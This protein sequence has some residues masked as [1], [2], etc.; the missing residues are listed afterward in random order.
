MGSAVERRRREAVIPGGAAGAYGRPNE[1]PANLTVPSVRRRPLL[2][3][4]PRGG[5]KSPAVAVATS[6]KKNVQMPRP[7]EFRREQGPM[8]TFS[9]LETNITPASQHAE[10][11][12]DASYDL[13]GMVHV[14]EKKLECFLIPA[15][16]A[17][18]RRRRYSAR[19]RGSV[20]LIAVFV[21]ALLSSLVIGMLQMNTEEI[22]LMQNHVYAV[23]ALAVAEAGLNDAFA[24]IRA[25]DDWDAG[26]AD[27]SFGAHVY[28]VKVSGTLPA[29][30]L[31]ST[32]TTSRGYEARV[33]ADVTVGAANPYVIRIDSLRINEDED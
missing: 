12:S 30:T 14:M 10:K 32:A 27:K 6:G 8:H 15:R 19:S 21:I 2:W 28:T 16:A 5:C 13:T 17:A 24:Q 3:D 33:A 1:S 11:T 26:F 18:G 31:E 9:F 29:L 25:D 7:A 23:E 4:R 22:Q 20:I